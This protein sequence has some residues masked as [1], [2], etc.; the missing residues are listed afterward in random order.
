MA[1]TAPVW[2]KRVGDSPHTSLLSIP[3]AASTAIY[4]GALVG[5]DSSGN[6][7]MAGPA[8]GGTVRVVGV[9]EATADNSGG[10]AAAINVSVRRGVFSFLTKASGGDNLTKVHVGA[11]AWCLDEVT[12]ENNNEG[13]TL[14]A[15]GVMVGVDPDISGN[16][17]VEVGVWSLGAS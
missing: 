15:A 5:I 3:V 4:E 11:I 14:V 17:F 10:G 16:V 9:A 6:A 13:S 1:I 2:R 7:I 12:V 8:G